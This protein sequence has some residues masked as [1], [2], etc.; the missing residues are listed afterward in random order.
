MKLDADQP[1][2][3]VQRGPRALA[4]SVIRHDQR[5]GQ[6][7]HPAQLPAH[8]ER[9]QV[10]GVQVDADQADLARPV[11]HPADGRARHR[12]P[13]GDLVLGQLVLV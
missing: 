8:R 7:E 10:V 3:R 11:Q 4:G 13:L 2:P 5:L 6:A 1:Q 12:Q 9:V